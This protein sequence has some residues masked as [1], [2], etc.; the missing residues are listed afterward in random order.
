MA[1]TAAERRKRFARLREFDRSCDAA[2]LSG[3]LL[4]GVDEAG[5]G[6]LAGPVVAAAVILPDDFDLPELFDS[7]QLCES[8]RLHCETV[9][10]RDAVH[11]AVARVAPTTIDSINILNAM[12]RAHRQAMRRLDVVPQLVLVDGHRAPR[13]PR[14]W[15]QV[16]LQT[17]VRG[18]SHSMSVAAASIVAKSVRDRIMKRLD[19]RYPEYGFADNKGY[20]TPDHKQAVRRFGLTPVHRR[21]FCRW[22]DDER[23]LQRQTSLHFD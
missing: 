5:V 11:L 21:S 3:G 18:D 19:R 23:L 1:R 10:R 6:P 4:V 7:K 8:D 2:A 20:G 13:L 9:I 15:S 14:A 17:V 12:L 16:R 22:L